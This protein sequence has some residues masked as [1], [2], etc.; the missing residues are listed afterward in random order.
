MVP[1]FGLDSGIQYSGIGIFPLHPLSF[2]RFLASRILGFFEI[3]HCRSFASLSAC[4]LASHSVNPFRSP[5]SRSARPS[6]W[7]VLPVRSALF[8][9]LRLWSPR[10][11]AASASVVVGRLERLLRSWRSSFDFLIRCSTI[12]SFNSPCCA[13]PYDLCQQ[14]CSTRA[15]CGPGLPLGPRPRSE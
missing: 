4:P 1:G 9:P 6:V 2:P 12:V 7:V 3:A 11:A 10:A 14:T 5:V 8:R 13:C 15:K